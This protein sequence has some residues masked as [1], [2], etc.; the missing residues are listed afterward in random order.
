M[1]KTDV[2]WRF[3]PSEPL[4]KSHFKKFEKQYPREW[5]SMFANL[6]KL[7]TYIKAGLSVNQLASQ[8]SFFRS[9]GKGLYRVGQSGG[10]E[11]AKESRLYVAFDESRHV[12][13]VLRVGT[14]ETQTRDI[15]EAKKMMKKLIQ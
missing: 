9:E 6:S 8:I 4:D 7:L 13:H 15:N 3:Q 12:V 11:S 10:I 2:G 14:K 5:C 1:E